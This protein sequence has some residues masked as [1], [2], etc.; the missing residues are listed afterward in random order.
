VELKY[1]SHRKN[2][3]IYSLNSYGLYADKRIAIIKNG[4]QHITKAPV[5]IAKV[6]AALRSLLESAESFDF[7]FVG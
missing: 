1:P 7:L 5:I 2:A 3:I 6:L 4:N